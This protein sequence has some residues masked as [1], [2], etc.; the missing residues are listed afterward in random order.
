MQSI[1]PSRDQSDL[2][3]FRPRPKV[4]V[5]YV[6][7]VKAGSSTIAEVLPVLMRLLERCEQLIKDNC[8]IMFEGDQQINRLLWYAVMLYYNDPAFWYL[9]YLIAYYCGPWH[10]V[11][12]VSARRSARIH[13]GGQSGGNSEAGA[14]YADEIS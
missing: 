7:V 5:Q 2:D 3:N 12:G 10:R 11:S 9:K 13:S 6:D 14:M 4:V 1:A 8:F